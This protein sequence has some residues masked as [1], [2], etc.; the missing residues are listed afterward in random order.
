MN[1]IV[2]RLGGAQSRG[3]YH[4]CYC[5]QFQ[6]STRFSIRSWY[7]RCPLSSVGN[8]SIFKRP[9]LI[10]IRPS[11]IC[12]WASFIFML[13]FKSNDS[14]E[15]KFFPQASSN[16]FAFMRMFDCWLPDVEGLLQPEQFIFLFFTIATRNKILRQFLICFQSGI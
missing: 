13:L 10:F 4:R 6:T 15:G 14:L 12:M 1:G 9:S 7:G 5:S 8:S 3:K 11:C 2:R 16:N